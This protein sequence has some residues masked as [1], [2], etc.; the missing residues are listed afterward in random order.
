M[1]F[2]LDAAWLRL[3]MFV[4]TSHSVYVVRVVGVVFASYVYGCGARTQRRSVSSFSSRLVSSTYAHTLARPLTHSLSNLDPHIYTLGAR[5]P[6]L[7][8]ARSLIT[9]LTPQSKLSPVSILPV[10][11]PVSYTYLSRP[12]LRLSYFRYQTQTQLLQ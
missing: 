5:R 1:W 11:V 9:S 3:Y 2:F 6:T 10:S 12:R 4:R 8:L 7:T